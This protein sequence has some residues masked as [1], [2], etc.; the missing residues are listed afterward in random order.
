MTKKEQHSILLTKWH[1]A[2]QN[3]EFDYASFT[4]DGPSNW[5]FY[6]NSFPRIL[7]LVKESPY[8]DYNPSRPLQP[9]NA[10]FTKNIARWTLL[11][12]SAFSQFLLPEM[13]LDEELPKKIDYVSI[14][15]VKKICEEKGSC[16]F[17]TM[18]VLRHFW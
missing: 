3:S 12:N 13:P 18:V 5:D 15:E 11:I 10:T 16:R 7:F 9:L 14:V 4:D 2:Y 1:Q 8:C 6:E 17:R